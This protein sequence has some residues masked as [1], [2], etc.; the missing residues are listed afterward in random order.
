MRQSLAAVTLRVA[1]R[2]PAAHQ[3]HP[4]KG[5]A[6][7]P[8]QPQGR[9]FLEG[10]ASGGHPC[11]WSKRDGHLGWASLPRTRLRLLVALRQHFSLLIC[12]RDRLLRL[13]LLPFFSW[14]N[15][16]PPGGRCCPAHNRCLLGP[17]L[18]CLLTARCPAFPSL[19]VP[20]AEGPLQVALPPCPQHGGSRGLPVRL[21]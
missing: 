14:R 19:P 21:G 4:G 2:P 20:A 10:H 9:L 5:D 6:F 7:F 18:P 13:V 1:P 15:F 8:A 3:C 17:C 16:D 11:R 12:W